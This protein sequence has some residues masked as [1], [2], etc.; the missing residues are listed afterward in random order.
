MC[1][2]LIGLIRSLCKLYIGKFCIRLNQC[3]GAELSMTISL[4]SNP[5]ES[6][7]FSEDSALVQTVEEKSR[8]LH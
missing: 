2:M 7:V 6:T 3:V 4:L 1:K 5:V 8:M